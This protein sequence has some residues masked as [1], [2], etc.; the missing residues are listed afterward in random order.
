MSVEI[1][2][3]FVISQRC[4]RE[5]Y[6]HKF[7]KIALHELALVATMCWCDSVKHFRCCRRRKIR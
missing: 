3:C 4:R 5:F 1:Q 6:V 7:M 2:I